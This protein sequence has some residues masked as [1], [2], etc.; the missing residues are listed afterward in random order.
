MV[1]IYNDEIFTKPIL[2]MH[3]GRCLMKLIFAIISIFFSFSFVV[4]AQSYTS[5]GLEWA[6]ENNIIEG[7]DN[8]E[9]APDGSVTRAQLAAMLTRYL[10]IETPQKAAI[11]SDVSE[12]DWFYPYVASVSSAG[13]MTGD[14]N[15]WRP[16][17]GVTREE[18]VTSFI[19]LLGISEEYEASFA[20]KND[21]SDWARPYIDTAA[22]NG[23][24]AD[25]GDNFRPRDIITRG[26]LADILYN[27][28]SFAGYVDIDP[29]E[30][31]DGSLWTP[32]YN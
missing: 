26:E 3:Y 11:Y 9:L 12:N 15:L 10:D 25:S 29:V 1:K 30:D 31:S 23:I 32:I 17:D 20:D 14:G 19:R 22:S 8:N 6:V 5:D 24:I 16:E 27:G 2:N 7:M 28:R 21:I 13:I 18:A 4:S